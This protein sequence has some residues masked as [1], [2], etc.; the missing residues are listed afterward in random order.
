MFV[1]PLRRDS[2]MLVISNTQ[3]GVVSKRGLPG[4]Y[5]QNPQEMDALPSMGHACGHNLIATSSLAAFLATT[6]AL[7]ADGGEGRVRILGTPAEEDGGGK[8]DLLRAGAYKGV[9][10]C[11]MGHPGPRV[12]PID[13]IANGKCMARAG[14]TATFK[15]V[16]AHAGNAPWQGRNALDAAVAAYNSISMLRQQITPDQRVHA[17]I[18]KGGERPN[19]IPDLTV[20]E[21]YARAENSTQL[22]DTCQRLIGCFEGAARG[23]GCT[24]ELDWYVI[25]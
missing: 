5:R 21:L 13:G 23:A 15:G 18:A 16:N 3:T 4:R 11:L 12:V 25:V 9:D 8:I 1:F 20:I 17:I 7:R 24:V 19:V 22:E 10:A 2:P 6:E 14:V